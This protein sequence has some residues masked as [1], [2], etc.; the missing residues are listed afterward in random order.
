[1][2]KIINLDEFTFIDLTHSLSSDI[3]HWGT[4]CGFQHKIEHDY[5]NSTT[6]VKFRTYNVQM[7]AGIG[8]H[9]DAPAHCIPNAAT[10][11]E[12]PL[13]SLISPCRMIDISDKAHAQYSL[14][15]DDIKTLENKYGMIPKE[16]FI[17][18][19]TGWDQ[20]WD[21]P[22]KYRNKLVFPSVSKEAAEVLIARD[23]VGLGIDTLSPDAGNSRFP[24]HQLI[25]SSGKYIVENIANAKMLDATGC[26]IFV[27]PIKIN[28]GTEAPVRLIGMKKN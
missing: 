28:D 7:V 12:I 23:I 1:M 4:A 24:V 13:R 8:T 9:M 3:P 19:Y 11:S 6:D 15:V 16:T 5:F 26:Y 17:I 27:L 25:L 22:E 10:I 14:T 18:V 20:W 21:Q 2:Q